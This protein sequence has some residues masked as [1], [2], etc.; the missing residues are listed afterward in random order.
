MFYGEHEHTVDEK[1]RLT[2][3]ARY[4]HA[5]ADGVV[6]AR[7]IERNVDVYPRE[8]WEANVARIADLDSLTREAREM[9]RF[10]FAG[11][12][13]TE[14]DRQGRVLLPPHLAAHAGLRK[15]VV[16][17]GVHDHIEIW[18]RAEWAAHLS[19]IEGSA[20]DVAER[21]ADRRS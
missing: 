12:V 7:G 17:L 5:L 3:P 1:S 8:S 21:L 9:K 20:S 16:V 15:D 14:L 18:D 10:V 11:A 4:R 6:L 13:P 2:L 19:A